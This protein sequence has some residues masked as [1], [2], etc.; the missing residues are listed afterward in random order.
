[1]GVVQPGACVNDGHHA[2]E[3]LE[4][5]DAGLVPFLG[6]AKGQPVG[7]TGLEGEPGL[8]SERPGPRHGEPSSRR[9]LGLSGNSLFSGVC[10]GHIGLVV[11]HV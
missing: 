7:I 8:T 4:A 6:A 11:A 10:H 3:G 2:A 1:M 5:R 9:W